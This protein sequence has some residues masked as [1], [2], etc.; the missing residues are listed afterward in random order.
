MGSSLE[1]GE[2]MSPSFIVDTWRIWEWLITVAFKVGLGNSMRVI[3]QASI[4]WGP[5]KSNG[6]SSRINVFP[7]VVIYE[8]NDLSAPVFLIDAKYKVLSDK[9]LTE[10]ERSDLYEGIMAHASLTIASGKIEGIN[11][12][13]KA[14]RNQAY[15]I[16]DD[17]YFFLKIMDTSRKAYVRNPKAHKILH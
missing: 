12:K 1:N 5:K 13:I 8:F 11:N 7:D 9:N 3:P 10:I 14:I 16:P 2:I 17:E 15:G 6:R 4:P